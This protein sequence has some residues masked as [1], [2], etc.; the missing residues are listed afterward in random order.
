[1]VA[2]ALL[3]VIAFVVSVGR[4]TEARAQVQG[5]A[6]DAARASTINHD[7]NSEA[8]ARE[9]F[10][11]ATAGMNCDALRA[12]P[13]AGGGRAAGDRHRH[14]PR[15]DDVGRADDHPDRA[16]GRRRLPGGGLMRRLRP[17]S[18]ARPT[19][20]SAALFVAIFAPAMIFLAGLVIDGGAALEVR[21]RAADIAEQAARAA[22]QQC[23]VGLLRSASECRITSE[24]GGGDGGGAVPGEQRGH[25]LGP[26]ALRPGPGRGRTSS[27]GCG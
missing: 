23:N 8:A 2:P 10:R 4:V 21:Q 1:M 27:T 25:R 22:G 3:L 15:D 24:A 13:A 18:A 19:R 7:G 20:G 5:A 9:A 16:V 6:R 11:K 17:R 26:G 14:L 12:R